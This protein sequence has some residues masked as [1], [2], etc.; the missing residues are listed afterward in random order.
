MPRERLA[1]PEQR[2]LYRKSLQWSQSGLLFPGPSGAP[3]SRAALHNALRRLNLAINGRVKLAGDHNNV[4]P[5]TPEKIRAAFLDR[6]P[7]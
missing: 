4:G 1:R 2:R 5:I 3:L 7:F 6:D